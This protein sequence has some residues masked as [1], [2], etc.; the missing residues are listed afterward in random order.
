MFSMRWK[1]RAV[2][3]VLVQLDDTTRTHR[4]QDGKGTIRSKPML[5][6]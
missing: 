3:Q 5:H 1:L 6:R 2:I 4:G